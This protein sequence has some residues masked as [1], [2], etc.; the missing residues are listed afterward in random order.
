M[1]FI[2]KAWWG[3]HQR[4]MSACFDIYGNQG[5]VFMFHEVKEDFVEN[6]NFAISPKSFEAFLCKARELYR[7]AE[8]TKIGEE[9]LKCSTAPFF[10]TFDDAYENIY[11]EAV[12]ILERHEIPFTVFITTEFIDKKG[13]LSKDMILQLNNNPICTI[14]AH[15]VS[16]LMHRRLTKEESFREVRESKSILEDMIGKRVELFAFPYGSLF[17][18]SKRDIEILAKCDFKFGFSTIAAPINKKSMSN[19]YFIPRIN[20]NECNHATVI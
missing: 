20:V 4:F 11:S 14:G 5:K 7:T 8:L 17:A 18:C 9:Y 19:P 12:P 10:V 15:G 16:H 13:Y 6:I 1:D 3:T 2:N